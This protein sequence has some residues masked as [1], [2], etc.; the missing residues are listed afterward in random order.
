MLANYAEDS[1]TD[2]AISEQPGW[3]YCLANQ[4]IPNQVK[5]GFTTQSVESRMRQLDTTGVA[6]PFILLKKWLSP[7]V[8]RDEATIHRLLAKYRT[9]SNREWFNIDNAHHEKLIARLDGYMVRMN[10]QFYPAVGPTNAQPSTFVEQAASVVTRFSEARE[11]AKASPTGRPQRQA[12]S[13]T[14]KRKRKKSLRAKIDL[15]LF[16]FFAVVLVV[17]FG[18]LNA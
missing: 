9:R 2:T 7:D 3:I 15:I 18:G 16:I 17:V 11:I 14:T 8:R 5:I 6:T 12:K 4:S 13:S 10:A 1:E